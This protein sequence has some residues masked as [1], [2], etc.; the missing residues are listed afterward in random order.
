MKDFFAEMADY[1]LGLNPWLTQFD[2][3][4]IGLHGF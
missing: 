2:K 3:L 1:R 4:E